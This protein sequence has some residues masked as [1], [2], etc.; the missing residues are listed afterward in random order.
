MI[1]LR[2]AAIGLL[3]AVESAIEAGDWKVDGACDPSVEIIRLKN[4]L[5]K[6]IKETFNASTNVKEAFNLDRGCWERGCM[7]YDTRDCDEGVTVYVDT[8]NMSQEH[9]DETAKREHEPAV[10]VV[11][12]KDRHEF[13]WGSKPEFRG[14]TVLAFQP[15]YMA[16]PKREW[17]GLTDEEIKTFQRSCHL[18]AVG[19]DTFIKRFAIGLEAKLKEKNT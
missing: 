11:Q 3:N 2:E 17:V 5:A 19:Y 12:Y 18:E 1:T 8:V 10:W 14:G 13:V 9:V 4:I 16:P 7:A 15:L 6:P